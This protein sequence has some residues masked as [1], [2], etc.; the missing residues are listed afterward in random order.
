MVC[1]DSYG[2][3]LVSTWVATLLTSH[4][5]DQPTK[6]I[7]RRTPVMQGNGLQHVAALVWE[8]HE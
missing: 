8:L 4:N 1:G 7:L 3:E 6:S 5:T 2:G